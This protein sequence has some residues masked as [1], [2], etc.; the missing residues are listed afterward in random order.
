MNQTALKYNQGKPRISLCPSW[1][2][3][4]MVRALEYGCVKY[5]QESWR[6]GFKVSD[7]YDATNRH[8]DSFFH[9]REDYD[10]ESGCHHLDC[11]MFSL[12]MMRYSV[13]VSGLD[14]RPPVTPEQIAEVIRLGMIELE[15]RKAGTASIAPEFAQLIL[16]GPSKE[17]SNVAS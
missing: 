6:K 17:T 10:E 14:N 15:K 4:M 8:M 12:A 2:R 1:L 16:E 13:D 5:F 7:M 9:D 11:A 3:I